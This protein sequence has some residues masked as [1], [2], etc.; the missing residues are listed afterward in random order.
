[1]K[2]GNAL[3]PE[4][5]LCPVD[6]SDLSAL[7]LKYAAVG[8]REF[9]A[10]LTVLHANIFDVPRYFSRNMDSALKRQIRNAK[11]A[12][13]KMVQDHVR[14]ILGPMA[15]QLTLSFKV[16]DRHPIDAISEEAETKRT[17]L[18]V[19]GTHGH[20]GLQRFLLGSV[21]ENVLRNVHVP[22]FTV[23]QKVHDFIDIHNV[24]AV[25]NIDSIL[26][27]CDLTPTAVHAL[28]LAAVMAKRF[29]SELIVLYSIESEPT[30]ADTQELDAWIVDTG[31][32]CSS[33]KTVVRKGKVP[34]QIITFAGD[35]KVDLII[36]GANHKPFMSGMIMG[37][38]TELVLRN[39]PVPV[40]AVPHL[41]KQS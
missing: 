40:L 2:K 10:E 25:P 4:R 16:V 12:V 34:E 7:A 19:L 28:R 41:V 30:H 13:G 20:S 3:L 38:A 26:C 24:D 27:P 18:I 31:V 32:E 17:D 22:I 36:L 37:K 33:L 21:T 15:D 11:K 8:A 1:M 6:F 29:Q 5:I 39:A 35:Q 14:K 9:R 23:R